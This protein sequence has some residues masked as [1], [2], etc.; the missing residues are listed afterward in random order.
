MLITTLHR[1]CIDIDFGY[2]HERRLDQA[3]YIDYDI[4]ICTASS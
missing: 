2:T 4:K 1:D 3:I